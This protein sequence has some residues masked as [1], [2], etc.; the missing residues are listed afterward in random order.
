M[1]RKPF[2]QPRAVGIDIGTSGV[3]AVAVDSEG[4]PVAASESAFKAASDTR[5]PAAWWTGV[6]NCLGDLSGKCTLGDIE[7]IAVDGTSGTLVAL[8][9]GNAPL[10][11]PAG[12][13]VDTACLYSNC[14]VPSRR[15]SIE[16]ASNQVMTPCSFTPFIRK[17]VSGV[18]SLRTALRNWS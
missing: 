2:G 10:G 5:S 15:S 14:A 18:L 9:A 12:T 4:R 13:I 8:D 7:G 3:R 16:K 1:N 11:M 6:E 17:M